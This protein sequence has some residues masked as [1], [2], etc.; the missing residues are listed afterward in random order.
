[1]EY[2]DFLSLAFLGLPFLEIEFFAWLLAILSFSYPFLYAMWIGC[3]NDK[4]FKK[5]LGRQGL[6]QDLI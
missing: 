1:M 4:K 6:D 3:Q 5:Q 2:F